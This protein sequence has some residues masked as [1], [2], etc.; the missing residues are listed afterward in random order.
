MFYVTEAA[1]RLV[2]LLKD[3]QSI[4]VT[5]CPG[6]GKSSLA[7]YVAIHM[8]ETE[9]YTVLP[10]LLPSE[11]LKMA[12][13][14]AKQLFI[15]DDVFGKYSLN[16]YSLYS[17]E[18]ES[19]YIHTLL[20]QNNTKVIVTCRS[21][22]FETVSISLFSLSL[23]HFNLHSDEMKLSLVER[24]EISKLYLTGEL[25]CQLRDDIIMMYDFFPLLC[26]MA[27]EKNI[28][29]VDFFRNADQF[30]CYEI[31]NFK[32]KK[33]LSLIAL[34]LLVLSNNSIEKNELQIGKYKYNVMLQDLFDEIDIRIA[35]SKTSILSNLQNLKT[36]CLAETESSFST[37]HDKLFD[38]ISHAM[39]KYIIRC[40]LRHGES[41]FISKR[42]Q[43][44]LLNEQHDKHT[45]MIPNDVT[46]MYFDRILKDIHAGH[47]WEVFSSIQ[48]KFERYRNLLVQYLENSDINF[49]SS[50]I[51]CTTPLHVAA[52]KGYTDISLYLIEK[53]KQQIRSLDNDNNSPLH[54]ASMKGHHEIVHLLISQGSRINQNNSLGCTPLLASCSNGHFEVAEGLLQGHASVNECENKGWYPLQIVAADG[55]NDLIE[56]LV[57]YKANVNKQMANGMTPLYVACEFGH[58]NAVELLIKCKADVNITENNGWFPLHV[59]CDRGFKRIA[60]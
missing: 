10:L 54:I 12:T 14:N 38:I 47:F 43:L 60:E 18:A 2:E 56:L 25:L 50:R 33:D 3:H 39:G 16:E 41:S 28:S 9:G 52:A 6:S 21:S 40:I 51:D 1:V 44:K 22:L 17:W 7:Y 58:F 45:I 4:I 15:F 34:A 26:F 30:L 55:N 49:A 23:M 19:R 37:K 5:G 29:N 42:L 48:M 53:N 46:T 24:K 20:K 13:P 31:E 35:P 59:A 32:F 57:K 8:Q 11:L 36:M 27:K